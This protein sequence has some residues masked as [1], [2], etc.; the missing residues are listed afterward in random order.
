MKHLRKPWLSLII[1]F[2]G[3]G[4]VMELL[5]LITG[6]LNRPMGAGQFSPVPQNQLPN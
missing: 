1:S 4:M 6:D 2:L 5:Q 3:G